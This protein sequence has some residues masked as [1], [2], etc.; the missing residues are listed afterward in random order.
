MKLRSGSCTL[1]S[2]ICEGV[3][4]SPKRGHEMCFQQIW[5]VPRMESFIVERLFYVNC[6][7]RDAMIYVTVTS[8]K[9]LSSTLAHKLKFIN[10]VSSSIDLNDHYLSPI[11]SKSARPN[12]STVGT[13]YIT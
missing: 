10:F 11:W 5:E 3:A 2:G 1:L 4:K 9:Y 7:M 8:K 13:S 6:A 12:Y